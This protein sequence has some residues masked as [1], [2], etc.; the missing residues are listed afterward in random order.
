[1]SDIPESAPG[2]EDAY[3]SE[4]HKSHLKEGGDK[5]QNKKFNNVEL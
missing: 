4:D 5:L 2:L 3:V 1:M